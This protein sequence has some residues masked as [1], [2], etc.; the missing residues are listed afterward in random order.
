MNYPLVIFNLFFKICLLPTENSIAIQINNCWREIDTLPTEI[1]SVFKL[2]TFGGKLKYY[3]SVILVTEAVH[4][5][6][7]LLLIRR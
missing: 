5:S 2:I 3:P 6:F 4:F 1:L 7:F